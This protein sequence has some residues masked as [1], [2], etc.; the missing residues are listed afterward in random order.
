MAIPT[1]SSSIVLAASCAAGRATTAVVPRPTRR[2]PSLPSRMQWQ[3]APPGHAWRSPC[4]DVPL[5]GGP[6]TRRQSHRRRCCK[7]SRTGHAARARTDEPHAC[8]VHLS[9]VDGSAGRATSGGETGGGMGCSSAA[10]GVVAVASG[11]FH[12]CGGSATASGV[13][14]MAA[15]VTGGGGAISRSPLVSRLMNGARKAGDVAATACVHSVQPRPVV[16]AHV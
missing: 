11:G 2:R 15:G 12:N 14:G 13:C 3:P 6:G 5:N 1:V 10:G 9:G 7:K 16:R 8:A 4:G